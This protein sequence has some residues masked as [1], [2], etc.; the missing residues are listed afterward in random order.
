[1]AAEETWAFILIQSEVTST[2]AIVQSYTKKPIEP[3]STIANFVGVPKRVR[4]AKVYH[5]KS[6]SNPSTMKFWTAA[7][8]AAAL[9]SIPSVAAV[10][11]G[12]EEEEILQGVSFMTDMVW[13][14]QAQMVVILKVGEV[15][16]YE[17]EVGDDPYSY[18]KMT[19]ALDISEKTCFNNERGLGG[20]QLHPNFEQNRWIYLYYTTDKYGNCDEDAD[21]GP[22]NRLSR[23]VLQEDNTI[24]PATEQIFFDT[25][26]LA[27]NMH[28]GGRLEF[29]KDGTFT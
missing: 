15:R 8:A 22:V 19:L 21:S 13:T 24:D 16:V 10:P 1:L 7:V 29:G 6:E 12:F 3:V 9:V 20:I 2:R 23:F 25:P 4:C 5:T 14:P 28:N 18:N 27:T 26:S 11:D 17:D